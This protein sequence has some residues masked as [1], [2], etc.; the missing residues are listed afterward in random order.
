MLDPCFGRGFSFI[1]KWQ[2]TTLLRDGV[3]GTEEEVVGNALIHLGYKEIKSC[4]MGQ[5]FILFLED[6]E[7]EEEQRNRVVEMCNKQLVN[8]ILYDF[9]VEPYNEKNL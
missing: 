8:T 9:K 5:L 4:K 7:T 3:K 1:M 6:N 2:V